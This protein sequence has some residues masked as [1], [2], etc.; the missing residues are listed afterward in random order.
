LKKDDDTNFHIDF[1]TACSNMRAWNYHINPATRHKCKMIAGRII[2]AIATT[3]AMITG[4]VEIELYKLLLGLDKAKFLCANVNLG[5]GTMRLFEPV[6]PK[7]EVARMDLLMACEV[8]PI[9][10][11]F[12]IWDRVVID[13]GDITVK[14]LID[15]FPEIHHGCT[16]EAV[17]FK[18]IKKVEGEASG[19]PIWVK[20]AINNEQKEHKT[21]NEALRISQIYSEQ[22]GEIP[23]TRNYILLDLTVL[24]PDGTDASVPLVQLVF[25]K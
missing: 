15:S 9:P 7:K 6:A 4:L 12:T 5:L 16:L 25:R 13:R 1:I 10:P 2:P 23:L 18:S 11:G 20:F 19:A 8:K 17:F 22:F 24:G 14:E 21:R 3:T